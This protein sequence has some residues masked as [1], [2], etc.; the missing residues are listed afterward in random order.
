[1]SY[2]QT[3]CHCEEISGS[4]VTVWDLLT[5][6]AGI[7]DWMPDGFIQDLQME[8]HGEGAV[9]HLV[10][11]KGV[12]ISERLDAMGRSAG[13]ILLSIIDPLPWGMLT[14]TAKA[15]LEAA[16]EENCRLSWCGSFELAAGGR[17]ADELVILLKKSYTTMFNGIRVE[18]A[19][20]NGGKEYD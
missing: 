5:D 3:V 9:R 8:G 2:R 19:R 18:L 12:H 14:Y 15:Q 20:K 13:I 16:G 10:T 1:V 4:R 17:L 6:W 7:I 11:G